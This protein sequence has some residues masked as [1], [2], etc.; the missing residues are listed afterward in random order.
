VKSKGDAEGGE[1]RLEA[2]ESVHA[3]TSPGHDP[4]LVVA[5]GSHHGTPI[6]E[7]REEE[8]VLRVRGVLELVDKDEGIGRT[9]GAA[10]MRIGAQQKLG[11]AIDA[12]E[13]QRGACA[14]PDL[15][16]P[17]VIDRVVDSGL[18]LDARKGRR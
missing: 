15:A 13:G 10:D 9:Q 6:G 18:R 3:R 5:H 11:Q 2:L 8:V 4:L 16:L 12:D 14:L 17:P 1:I 7:R